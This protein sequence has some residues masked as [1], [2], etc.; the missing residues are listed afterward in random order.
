MGNTRR[1]KE[2]N[3]KYEAM[4]EKVHLPAGTDIKKYTTVES[5]KTGKPKWKVLQE[6]LEFKQKH[7]HK[8]PE[9]QVIAHYDEFIKETGKVIPGHE[10]E[11]NFLKKLI[12]RRILKL[13]NDFGEDP[14]D[15]YY[16]EL[17]QI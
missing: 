16:A 5:E 14:D 17:R 3:K 8:T 15:R 9:E 1:S 2:R 12:L 7:N 11:L 13:K 6:L 4:R 10:K